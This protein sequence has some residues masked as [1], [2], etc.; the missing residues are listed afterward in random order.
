MHE[1]L[2]GVFLESGLLGP[3][4]GT[5]VGFLGAVGLFCKVAVIVHTL[6]RKVRVP[7]APY[8]CQHLVFSVFLVL[9]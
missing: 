9:V 3:R 1:F 6:T 5:W 7:G 8:P 2:L 4:A